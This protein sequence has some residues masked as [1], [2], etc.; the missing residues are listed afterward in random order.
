LRPSAR[1]EPTGFK[2]GLLAIGRECSSVAQFDSD[3]NDHAEQMQLTPE[4]LAGVAYLVRRAEAL[5]I[6]DKL[7]VVV[8]SE[9]GRTPD[10]N[11]GNGKDHWSV[12]SILFMGLGVREDRAAGAT[13]ERQF[14]VPLNPQTLAPERR[15]ASAF[16][17]SAST[18]P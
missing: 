17:R 15:P 10:Y 5:G 16:G 7:V 12:G 18:P 11:Q 4:L 13:D 2:D 6:R 14:H 8:Q 1:E 9:M 3:A